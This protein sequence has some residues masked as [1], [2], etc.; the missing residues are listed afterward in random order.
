M[1]N[2]RNGGSRSDGGW[3]EDRR[4]PDDFKAGGKNAAQLFL[5]CEK[6]GATKTLANAQSG[7]LQS[8]L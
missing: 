8:L 2:A 7:K 5:G 4:I 3:Y 6:F 1:L